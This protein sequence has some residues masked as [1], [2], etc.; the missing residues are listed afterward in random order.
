MQSDSCYW[1]LTLQQV[2]C[3]LFLACV[4]TCNCFAFRM[5]RA[6]KGLISRPKRRRRDIMTR[7]LH[8]ERPYGRCL[9]L[10]A[11]QISPKANNVFSLWF[12]GKFDTPPTSS[13][14][15]CQSQYTWKK[16]LS[17]RWRLFTINSKIIWLWIK[18][19][20]YSEKMLVKHKF[21]VLCF[22]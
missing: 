3:I 14:H 18:W 6:Q 22:W 20:N 21:D 19:N 13:V 7:T 10:L 11:P 9:S 17:Y 12:W 15:G 8:D 2:F 4:C 16:I 1:Q 5:E